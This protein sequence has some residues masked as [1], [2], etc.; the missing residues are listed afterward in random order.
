MSYKIL[1]N[2]EEGARLERWRTNAGRG[3]LVESQPSKNARVGSAAGAPRE[4][5]PPLPLLWKCCSELAEGQ[6]FR[7]SI[8]PQSRAVEGG[9]ASGA[10]P[11]PG[12]PPAT[13]LCSGGRQEQ[14]VG[15][16]WLRRGCRFLG[17]DRTQCHHA[18]CQKPWDPTDTQRFLLRAPLSLVTCCRGWCSRCADNRAIRPR[19]VPKVVWQ[20]PPLT[21][22]RMR[23]L[24]QPHPAWAAL[25]V[26]QSSLIGTWKNDLNS[27]ME[28]NSIGN[29]GVFSG[30]CKT[31]V[32]ASDNPI[33]PSPLQAIQHQGPQPTF[34]LTLIF[35]ACIFNLSAWYFS[36]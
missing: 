35:I 18:E 3:A 5:M 13:N 21:D 22:F 4:E 8:R 10:F 23:C 1:D 11:P 14:L 25:G 27:T 36:C 15:A 20:V 28:I 19:G 26:G 9:C 34:G 30:L 31:A 32:S 24:C 2:R 33:G 7:R 16:G 17:V 29:T 6:R 12:K